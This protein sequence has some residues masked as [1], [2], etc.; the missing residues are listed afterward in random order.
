MAFD[1]L[2]ALQQQYELL[3]SLYDQNVQ[4]A[5][6]L[7]STLEHEILPGLV[8]EE[9]WGEDDIHRAVEWLRDTP[10]VFR[11]LKRH[12]LTISLALEAL[13]TTLQWRLRTLPPLAGQP[14][15]PYFTCLPSHAHDPFGRPIVVI[16]AAKLLSGTEDL[17]Q[18]AVRTSEL[19]RAHLVQL[20]KA[21]SSSGG[22][23]PILQYVALLDIGGMS[24]NSMQTIDLM[25]WHVQELL[26]RFPGMLAA[27]LILNYSWAHAGA[28]GIA[29]R[30]LPASTLQKLFFVGPADLRQLLSPRVLPKEYGGALPPIAALP[31]ALAD[32]SGPAAKA[33]PGA[34]EGEPDACTT[35]GS[36]PARLAGTNLR[37]VL[38]SMSLLNP[39]FGYPAAYDDAA[40]P[41]LRH[42]R[43]RKRDLLYTLVRLWWAR[44]GTRTVFLAVLFV[45]LLYARRW[46][47]PLRLLLERRRPGTLPVCSFLLALV[48]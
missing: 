45:L 39:F 8:D 47:T 2:N 19:M 16:Q 28:W 15:M 37:P 10:S 31:N 48:P 14:A 9:G 41:S 33:P 38:S 12:N 3:D 32:A 7:Q 23:R 6:Q 30:V 24:L 11:M 27:V 18:R 25:N 43:R 34:R 36:G 4:A 42:G 5:R 29:R 44:W 35:E 21:H 17:K 1:I 46:R 22:A 20:N 40:M 26:P 13:R